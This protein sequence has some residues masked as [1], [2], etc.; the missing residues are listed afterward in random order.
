[1]NKNRILLKKQNKVLIEKKSDEQV[2]PLNYVSTVMK[3]IEVLGYTLGGDVVEVLNTYTVT[4]ASR[5]YRELIK[6]LR[7][8]YGLDKIAD[9]MYPNFPEQV[10]EMSEAELYMNA[11]FHYY[12]DAIGVRIMPIYEKKERPELTESFKMKVINLG[13]D[14]DFH[15][16]FKGLMGSKTS[17]SSSDAALLQEYISTY[18][19]EIQ[20]P[21][22][23]PH[24]EVMST[25]FKAVLKDADLKPD[26][27]SKYFKTSTDV[28]RLA[29]ALSDGDVSLAEVTKF[30]K[31][32]KKERRFF[33]ELINNI[34]GNITEDMLRYK[35]RW[36]R[37]GEILH[38]GDY[39]N[40]Y[41]RAFKAFNAI[42][43]NHKVITFNGKVEEALAQGDA[44]KAATLLVKRP[45]EFARRLDHLIRLSKKADAKKIVQSFKSVSD[46]VAVPVLLQVREHFAHRNDEKDL[47]VVFPKGNVGKVQA[48]ENELV[49]IPQDIC[50][51]V[52]S[53]CENG[54]REQF[55]DKETLGKVYLDEKLKDQIVPFSQR[56]A[57]EGLR[58]LVRGSRVE[59]PEGDTIRFF[60][61][62]KD[63]DSSVNRESAWG[64]Y[65]DLRVDVD[66]SAV[67]YDSDWKYKE[68]ISYTNL[69]SSKYRSCHSGDITSAP[70]GAEEYVD[71]HI[72]S[73]L[74]YG[75][76]YVVMNLYSFTGQPFSMMPEAFAGWMIRKEPKKGKILDA[77]TVQDRIDITAE[78]KISIPVVFDLE[79]RKFIWMDLGFNNHQ[80][81]ASSVENSSKG[82]A[83]MAK[84]IA[85]LVKP[86]LYDLFRLHIEARDGV[87]VDDIE[88]ADNVFSLYEGITPF[89][90]EVII[91]E[92]L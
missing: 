52:V 85:E 44:V 79:E 67:M 82:V 71:L 1:M 10:M 12:G 65:Y 45:G 20:L 37:L 33:L 29:V 24:K 88:D 76:R 78:T 30:R 26:V 89:D 66:L 39:R 15:N 25:V 4:E 56:S 40:R 32:S 23:I 57:S 70:N 74:E 49:N 46:K 3:N 69:K 90:T 38:P 17:I 14:Q 68:H 9:P 54:I 60:C 83:L 58:T 86:N 28:L 75:A 81:F 35:T 91:S 21:D 48:I 53:Y 61:H 19:S 36:I 92:Y 16:I 64:G 62:W 72:P 42:R 27:L 50:D 7:E 77:R 59:I 6:D 34:S 47:R 87:I 22:E 51:S 11:I 73:M 5:F 84:S 43:N 18:K 2:L 8:M 80:D 31:M 41:R 63:L 13:T 55:K